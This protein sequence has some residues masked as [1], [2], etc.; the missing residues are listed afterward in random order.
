MALNSTCPNVCVVKNTVYL[1]N[2]RLKSF[3]LRV[4]VAAMVSEVSFR[5]KSEDF[6]SE[7]GALIS[8]HSFPN[9]QDR[10]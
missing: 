4:S 3:H 5:Q 6:Q 10:G 8:S 7:F 2:R 1:L 9:A